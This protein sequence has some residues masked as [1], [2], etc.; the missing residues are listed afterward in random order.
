MTFEQLLYTEVLS[1]HSSLQKAADVLHISKPG[2]SSA[3]SDLENELGVK[4]FERTTKGTV[5]TQDGRKLL[6]AISEI[7]RSKS[8]LEQLA[9]FSESSHRKEIVRIRYINTMFKAFMNPFI[10]CYE[11][12]YSR[13]FYDISCSSTKSIITSVRNGDIDAG[14]IA[15]SDIESEWIKD[16][17]FRPVCEGKIV[18]GV[19][20]ESTLLGKLP[21]LEE[22]KRQ[23]YCI[24]DDI[25]HELLF[26]KLQYLCGPLDLILKTDDHWA[27]TETVKKLNAVCVGR[28]L[29]GMFSR[30][31]P[32]NEIMPVNI[33]HLIN[34]NVTMGWLTNPRVKRSDAAEEMI[35]QITEE[36]S[37]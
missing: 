14:F 36:L 31:N 32:E 22:L 27:V 33:G 37:R 24:Y 18:L 34:D 15:S 10:N 12:K 6:A 5:V 21:D 28:N 30:E 11:S 9:E 26:D 7:L 1:H 23:K 35:E 16:L 19:S 13:V 4:I 29:Q 25:Y 17:V 3:V 2:L 8:N 20:K